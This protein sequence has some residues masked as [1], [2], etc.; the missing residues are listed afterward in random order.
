MFSIFNDMIRT[1]TRQD[2]REPPAR[3]LPARWPAHWVD[4]ARG[5][6]APDRAR[7]ARRRTLLQDLLRTGLR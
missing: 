6:F 7:A 3:D 1:A 5:P 4:P 2:G